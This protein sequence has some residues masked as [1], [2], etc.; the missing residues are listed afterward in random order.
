MSEFWDAHYL[1]FRLND[2]SHFCKNVVLN[3]LKP[4]DYVIE[5]GCGN[6]RDAF[7]IAKSVKFY[8]GID[9]SQNAVNSTTETLVKTGIKDSKYMVRQGD[10]SKLKLPKQ[11]NERLVIYSRFSLHSV[12]EKSE[13]TFLDLLANYTGSEL[14]VLIEARTIFDTLFGI[15]NLVEKN[16]YITDHYRRFIDPIEFKNRISKHFIIDSFE[17]NSGFAKFD[18]QDPIVLRAVFGNK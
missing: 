8:E 2:P 13:N 11:V 15:G 1:N 3:Y 14:L 18:D 6:G 10:F 17:V 4:S 5:V 16:A 12:S 7:Q 9:L